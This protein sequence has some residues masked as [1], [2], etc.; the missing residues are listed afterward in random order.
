MEIWVVTEVPG[1]NDDVGGR[2]RR[3]G[4]VLKGQGEAAVG[5]MNSRIMPAG[6]VAA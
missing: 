4:K 5:L 1:G 2:V 6:E 3:I